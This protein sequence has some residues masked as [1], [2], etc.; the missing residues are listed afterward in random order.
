MISSIEYSVECIK[1][2]YKH[3]LEFGIYT[4]QTITKLRNL[5][6]E[7]YKIFGFDSFEGL[8]ED[9]IGTPCNKGFFDVGGTIPNILGVDFYKGWF[10]ETLALYKNISQPISLLHIDCDLYSS[11]KDVLYTLNSEI[12][13]QTI[14]CFDEWIYAKC[15]GTFHNDHEQ[16][17]FY[18]W[19]SDNN[20][21]FEFVEFEDLS[22]CGHERKIV[23]ILK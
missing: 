3:V 11:T 13:P 8:P 9:W 5:L 20:R 19:C 1:N 23:R 18:E 2:D 17:C 7:T 21:S 6:D 14:I 16:K 10:S 4:G 22:P 12:L 15:D